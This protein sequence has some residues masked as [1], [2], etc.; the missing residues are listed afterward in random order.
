MSKLTHFQC[1]DCKH[2]YPI[3]EQTIVKASYTCFD[4]ESE[5]KFGCY[6]Y[7]VQLCK[8]CLALKVTHKK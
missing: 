5:G 3:N 1:D 4:H 2:L 7:H 6:H 8:N